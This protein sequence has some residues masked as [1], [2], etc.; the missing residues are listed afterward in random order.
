MLD[1]LL[2]SKTSTILIIDITKEIKDKILVK[3]SSIAS[4]VK[5]IVKSKSRKSKETTSHYLS[6]IQNGKRG[7][8][9][10]D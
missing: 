6:L 10:S 7:R 4:E 9:G 5:E 2:N 1:Q 3:A 8:D